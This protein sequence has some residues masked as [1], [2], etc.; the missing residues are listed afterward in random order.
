VV[1]GR[2]GDIVRDL[3]PVPGIEVFG[4][5]GLEEGGVPVHGS[6][7]EAVRAEVEHIAARI[8]GAW[9]ED[10][11]RTMA[12]HYR[13]AI[14][15][16]T[17]SS[18]LAPPLQALAQDRGLVLFPGKMVLELAPHE[19]PGKGSVIEEQ[20]RS[21]ALA[22]CLYAGDDAADL[23]AFAAMDRLREERVV[24]VKVA[25]RSPETPPELVS[26]AD[27][28]VEGTEGLLMLLRALAT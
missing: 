19:V 7:V 4:L 11:G 16:R 5:Y 18:L 22:A 26:R 21:R 8:P 10:K 12:V 1:S 28:V 6:G 9:V 13:Q 25:V 27:L 24:A 2:P 20:A 17:A 15:P 3:L 23:E 14:D